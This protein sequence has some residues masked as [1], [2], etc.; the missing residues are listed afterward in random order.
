VSI[1]HFHDSMSPELWNKLLNTIAPAH[2][3]V[4]AWLEP[5]GPVTTPASSFSAIG[6]EALR[7]SR[8]AQRR[9]YY[10]GSGFTKSISAE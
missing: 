9:M 5:Q 3:R 1:L 10:M 4:S 2:P 8:G 6:R 7:I